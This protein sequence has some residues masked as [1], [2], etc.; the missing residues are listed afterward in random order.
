MR[1]N[2]GVSLDRNKDKR[3]QGRQ[4]GVG[5]Q[6]HSLHRKRSDNTGQAEI[7]SRGHGNKHKKNKK[8]ESCTR[9]LRG[10]F[11][12]KEGHF[13]H[14]LIY[15]FCCRLLSHLS[16]GLKTLVALLQTLYLQ[17]YG[18]TKNGSRNSSRC[19]ANKVQHGD[20]ST[21]PRS[22][23][24]RN[25]SSTEALPKALWCEDF[26]TIVVVVGCLARP[27][28]EVKGTCTRRN[29]GTGTRLCLET[30][31]ASHQKCLF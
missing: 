5:G 17:L 18:N 16:S 6:N 9:Q 28:K 3:K 4:T 19:S 26:N 25:S 30:G 21:S 7:L 31:I 11:I 22:S 8:G 20:T 23:Q 15:K 12:L 13:V 1:M 29:T 24:I 27:V 10:K 2:A 14:L